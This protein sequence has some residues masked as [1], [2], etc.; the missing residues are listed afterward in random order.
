MCELMTFV[1]NMTS[2]MPVISFLPIVCCSTRF[3]S[4]YLLLEWFIGFLSPP[5]VLHLH[6]MLEESLVGW[7][8]C[9]KTKQK[10]LY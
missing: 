5:T 10:K 2:R 8:D 6:T 1:R 7:R 3:K 9:P 4:V